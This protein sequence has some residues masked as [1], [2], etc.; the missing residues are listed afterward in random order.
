MPV[1]P[2]PSEILPAMEQKSSKPST[3][4]PADPGSGRLWLHTSIV[5]ESAFSPEPVPPP[6]REAK[7][8]GDQ[9]GHR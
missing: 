5:R 9:Q 2:I 3:T 6:N 1:R 7:D 8:S 4:R